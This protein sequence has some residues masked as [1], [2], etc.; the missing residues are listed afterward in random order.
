[1]R[2]VGNF[3]ILR[4]KMSLIVKVLLN[5]RGYLRPLYNFHLDKYEQKRKYKSII[6]G[7]F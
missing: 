2:N 5:D 3:S 1:M 6:N 4:L 7:R